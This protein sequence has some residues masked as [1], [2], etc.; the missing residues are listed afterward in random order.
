MSS[1]SRLLDRRPSWVTVAVLAVA[2][3]LVG[4]YLLRES[5]RGPACGFGCPVSSVSNAPGP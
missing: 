2:S 1:L 4:L 5:L 3:A